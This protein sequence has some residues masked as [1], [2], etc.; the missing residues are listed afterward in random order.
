M[1]RECFSCAHFYE[2]KHQY[3]PRVMVSEADFRNFLR[4][5]EDF[6]EW[7]YFL[8]NRD[9][10]FRAEI[11]NVKPFFRK[12]IFK[13][14]ERA[15]F[16]G[17]LLTTRKSHIGIDLLDDLAFIAISRGMQ[18]KF[19]FAAGDIITG[20]ARIRLDEGRI[21]FHRLHR[22]DFERRSGEHS[23]TASESWVSSTVHTRFPV[24]PDGCLECPFGALVDVDYA[25]KK[26]NAPREL[27]CLKGVQDY[28]DCHVKAEFCYRNSRN[29]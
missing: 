27:W 13:N 17:F 8:R 20:K 26:G 7:L 28:R 1:G 16:Q 3:V 10:E 9:L 4:Q 6:E 19:H 14:R 25:E 29:L 18:E 21:I 22:I 23:W 12:K 5:L 2:E 11:D 24:Q 15:E